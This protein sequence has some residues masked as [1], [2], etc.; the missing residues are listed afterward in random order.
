M[1][2]SPCREVC[3]L[4]DFAAIF[5]KYLP[6]EGNNTIQVCLR[7]LGELFELGGKGEIQDLFI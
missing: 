6:K 4:G 5:G 2:R 1:S 7:R 3:G